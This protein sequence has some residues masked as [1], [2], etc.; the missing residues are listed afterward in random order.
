[1]DDL[2]APGAQEELWQF[3]H[4]IVNVVLAVCAVIA[5]LSLV[6]LFAKLCVWAVGR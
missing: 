3:L 4:R 6:V 1:M 5:G 2:R